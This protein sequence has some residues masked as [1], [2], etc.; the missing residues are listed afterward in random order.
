MHITLLMVS[1]VNGFTTLAGSRLSNWTSSED[2]QFLQ[3]S[4]AE[5]NLL[6]MG[7]QTYQSAAA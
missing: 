2:F 1:S 7:R 3:K 6:V 5:H 4:I